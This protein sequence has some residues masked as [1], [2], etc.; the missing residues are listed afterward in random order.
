MSDPV[1]LL[2]QIRYLQAELEVLARLVELELSEG[3]AAPVVTAAVP[4]PVVAVPAAVVPA[5]VAAP[6]APEVVAEAA[7]EEAAPVEVAPVETAPVETAVV[8]TTPVEVAPV[9]TAPVETAPVEAV[10]PRLDPLP[11]EPGDAGPA[12]V[13]EIVWKLRGTPSFRTGSINATVWEAT[14]D[15]VFTR[16]ELLRVVEDLLEIGALSSTRPAEAIAKDFL[17]LVADRGLVAR[18]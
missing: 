2:R 12:E 4:A 5:V 13:D 11:P 10:G 16:G 17:G 18:T 14:S 3:T 1:S 9:E 6:A 15:L 7:P 8:E